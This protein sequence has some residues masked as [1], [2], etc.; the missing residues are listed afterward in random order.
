MKITAKT[1]LET[2]IGEIG[3]KEKPAGSNRVKYNTWYY[4]AKVSG[5]LYP[6]CAVF[7]SWVFHRAGASKLFC[8]G[9]KAAYCPDIE[10]YYKN[11]G[12]WHAKTDGKKGDICLMD[13]GK[14]RASHVGIVEKKN[15]DG[16]YTLIE[17]NTSLSSNDNGGCVM[18]RTRTLSVI[19][20]FGRPDYA[21]ET[22]GRIT[23]RTRCRLYKKASAVS[24]FYSSL[25]AGTEVEYISDTKTGWSK[26]RAAHTGI[27]HTGYVKNSCLSGRPDLSG[28]RKGTICVL[29][30]PLRA[31]NKKSSRKLGTAKKGT[32]FTVVSVGK[33]WT[34]IKYK[35]TDAFVF[36]KK[37]KVK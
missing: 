28:Y 20:G 8:G 4:G 15:P 37:I 21:Q 18:R 22:T 23:I 1:V 27:M 2:A 19:R 14:G 33:F 30:A 12:R 6:W 7:V 24:G 35:K 36:N 5:S 10:N 34:N 26:V 29:S 13:F 31:K 3:T 32:V 17:G 11:T 16:T 9:K 25:S